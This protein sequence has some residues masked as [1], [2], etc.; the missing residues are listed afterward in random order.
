MSDGTRPA[1]LF[2]VKPST[3]LTQS[4][5][6]CVLARGCQSPLTHHVV[7]HARF[8]CALSRNTGD[9]DSGTTQLGDGQRT[10]SLFKANLGRIADTMTMRNTAGHASSATFRRTRESRGCASM[11]SCSPISSP[12]WIVPQPSARAVPTCWSS[13]VPPQRRRNAT[14]RLH[15][16]CTT[17]A[18]L[19][20]HTTLGTHARTRTQRCTEVQRYR[21]SAER[22]TGG[23]TL[24]CGSRPDDRY[25]KASE[26]THRFT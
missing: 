16:D 3:S 17:T 1:P 21:Q 14:A 26:P 8:V 20:D 23:S 9:P 25:G 6:D 2:H 7:R 18:P 11:M 15:H 24:H 22:R 4:W 12:P 13:A 5:T 19:H 10:M